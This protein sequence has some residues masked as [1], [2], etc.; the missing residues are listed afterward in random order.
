MSLPRASQVFVDFAALLRAHG[1]AVSPDQT[2][3]FIHA[4]GLL[5]PRSMEDIRRAALSTLAVRHERQ[6][7]FDA[8]FGGFFLG[9]TVAAAASTDEEADEVSAYEETGQDIEV[10]EGD[11]PGE[12]GV[13]ATSAESLRRREVGETGTEDHLQRLIR[14]GPSRL[15]RRLSYRRVRA[16]GGDRLDLRRMLRRAVQRDGEAT[17]LAFLRRKTRQRRVVLMI[18][19]SG[20]M[21]EQTDQTF[22]FAH[23]LS[24]ICDR[25]E[26]FTFGTRLTRITAAL[27]VRNRQQ[28]LERASRL[29]ADFDGGTRIGEA[30][31]A[32]WAVPRYAG[33]I[34]GAAVLILSDGLE[35]GPPDAMIDS[36]RRISRIAWRVDWLTPLAADQGYEPR[37]E[38]LAS[39]LPYLNSLSDGSR[40]EAL[41]DHVLQMTRTA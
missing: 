33:F 27:S 34:R 32:F 30:L 28:A 11:D 20:S 2:M 37:T 8:L 15:P 29:I 24:I 4:V 13:E 17:D 14:L 41:S 12:A 7:E 19:V 16:R 1:F 23:A 10:P 26:A 40:T 9:Q 5:G 22:Q 3:D 31:Q 38:A 21:K 35:R 6:A 18:D 36:V 25:F 39:V